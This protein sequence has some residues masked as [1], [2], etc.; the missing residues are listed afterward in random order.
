MT[1]KKMTAYLISNYGEARHDMHQ[2]E[3]A[4]GELAN[5]H[6]ITEEEVFLFIVENRPINGMYTHSYGFNTANG[7]A[8]KE[9]FTNYY[10][11]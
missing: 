5:L 4:C 1:A 3:Y 10:N 6:D 2:M 11:N 8:L 9:Q 7:R